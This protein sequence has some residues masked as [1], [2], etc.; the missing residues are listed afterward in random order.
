MNFK[1]IFTAWVTSVNPNEEEKMRA[2]KR[3]EICEVCP[4]KKIIT[5]AFKIGTVC[6]ECGCPIGKKIFSPEFN[7]CPLKK[8][9]EID[10]AHTS[11][12]KKTK[13]LL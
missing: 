13:T 11:T 3:A 2:T 8:W 10:L 12:I 7:A 5:T 6:G 1:E 4:S 9:Q